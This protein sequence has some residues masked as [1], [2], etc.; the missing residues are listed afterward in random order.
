MRLPATTAP[1]LLSPPGATPPLRLKPVAYETARSVHRALLRRQG[2]RSSAP[3]P[4]L[5][6]DSETLT[7]FLT[8]LSLHDFEPLYAIP[9][10]ARSAAKRF[11]TA[12]TA[13]HCSVLPPCFS[14]SLGCRLDRLRE[15]SVHRWARATCGAS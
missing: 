12:T 5:A 8:D 15:Q 14:G 2:E 11:R 3:S 13:Y 9:C 7:A 10:G 1:F 6:P 4:L